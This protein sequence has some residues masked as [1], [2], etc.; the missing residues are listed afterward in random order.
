MTTSNNGSP[1]GSAVESEGAEPDQQLEHDQLDE[2]RGCLAE[3]D[4]TRLQ[5]GQS[6]RIEIAVDRLHG[7]RT[8]DRE[9]RREQHGEPEE[10]RSHG[11]QDG[12]TPRPLPHASDLEIGVDGETEEQEDEQAE[13]HHLGAEHA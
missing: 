10:P 5:T 6:E 2:H 13:R 12:P 7:K 1:S 9:Q 11:L 4:P 3:K 8:A